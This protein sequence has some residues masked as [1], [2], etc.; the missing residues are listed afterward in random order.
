MSILDLSK[1]LMFF[2]LYRYV[3]KKWENVEVLYTDT[4]SLV[5]KI[6]TEDFFADISGDVAEWFDT[7]EYAK[8]HP[9]VLEGLP[10]VKENKK[11]IGLMKDECNGKILTEWVGL[12]P[13][14]YSLLTEGGEKQKAKGLAK[15]MINKSLRHENFLKCLRTGENQK[16]KQ[17]LFRSRDHHIFTENMTKVA[18]SADDDKRIVLGNR[19]DTWAIGHWRLS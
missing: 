14:L 15:S 13:K 3:K 6:E 4:D 18:L 2:F 7:N 9:A 16:R 10:I 11:K 8:D 5:L 1:T 12:R 19:V 17:C